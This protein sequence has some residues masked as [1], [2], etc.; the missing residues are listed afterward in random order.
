MKNNHY[1][2]TEVFNCAEIGKLAIS[3]FFKYHKTLKLNVYGFESDLEK[4]DDYPNL[5]KVFLPKKTSL[6]SKILSENKLKKYFKKGHLGTAHLWNH[7]IN[8][9]NEDILLHFDSDVIFRGELINSMLKYSDQY[10]IIGPARPYKKNANNLNINSDL[11]DVCQTCCFLFNKKFISNY[12]NNKLR[13]MIQ[14]SYNPLGFSV[15][16]FFDPIMFDII[17]NGGKTFFLDFDTVGGVNNSG[18]R[19]NKFKEINDYE[20]DF[21]IDFG[22]K[23]IHFSAVG[24]GLNFFHNTYSSKIPKSYV[25]YAIDRYALYSKIYLNKDIGINLDKYSR[26]INFLKKNKN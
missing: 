13:R 17:F 21:K 24:S 5:N 10:Q 11:P 9:Q 18:S 20:T 22:E 25:D 2:W 26:L 7:I 3:T 12:N 15:I 14:G 23:L 6:F 1:I 8:N 16:D 4:I 19:K